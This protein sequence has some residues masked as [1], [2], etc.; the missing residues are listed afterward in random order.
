MNREAGQTLNSQSQGEVNSVPDK[1]GAMPSPEPLSKM[2]SGSETL[3]DHDFP[4]SQEA[5]AQQEPS[6]TVDT[7]QPPPEE[8][9]S[10]GRH[11]TVKGDVQTVGE[12]PTIMD[13]DT[14][15]PDFQAE[16]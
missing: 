6:V 1:A 8:V 2:T 16:R 9:R 5:L 13:Q 7:N 4:A 11:G 3:R 15:Q 12:V 14:S 10:G